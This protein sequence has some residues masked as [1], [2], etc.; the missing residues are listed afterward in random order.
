MI[1]LKKVSKKYG[2]NIILDNISFAFKPK[3]IYGIMGANGA[4]KSTLFRCITHLEDYVGEIVCKEHCSIG[5]LPDTSFFYP[6]VTG[7]EFLHFVINARGQEVNEEEI[8]KLNERFRLPLNRFA[9][10]YSLGMK[11]RLMIMSLMLTDSD[12][13]VLDEP[14]NGLDLVG[15]VILRNWIRLLPKNG[16]T[17]IIS[18]HIVS[19][20]TD[21]CDEILF[22]NN[23]KI[24]ENYKGEDAIT[25]E[26]NIM[27][28]VTHDFFENEAPYQNY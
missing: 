12:L 28:Y 11:K 18:S 16:K 21:I 3:S 26:T 27:N 13:Y 14:F 19:S 2:N 22:L 4:G 7:L 20:L 1:E 24:V 25:I 10:N 17:V 23:G 6:M 15:T 9:T 8:H 5:Y